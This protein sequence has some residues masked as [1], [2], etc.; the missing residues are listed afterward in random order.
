MA[1]VAVRIVA[2]GAGLEAEVQ[3]ASSH[4]IE[5]GED[6]T[7]DV[8]GVRRGPDPGGER[9]IAPAEVQRITGRN[10]DVA[11]AAVE[12]AFG[13]AGAVNYAVMT[14]AGMVARITAERPVADHISGQ[15]ISRGLS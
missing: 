1:I 4:R 6:V 12:L 3:P 10:L 5:L 14:M 15:F 8:F 11:A 7:E 2:A 9:E 13:R